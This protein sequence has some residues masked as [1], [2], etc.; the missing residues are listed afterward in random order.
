M[1]VLAE[2]MS[3]QATGRILDIAKDTISGWLKQVEPTV[4]LREKGAMRPIRNRPDLWRESARA[5]SR[6]GTP[7]FFWFSVLQFAIVLP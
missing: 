3:I 5:P 7:L 2:G 4:R 6:E 1:K